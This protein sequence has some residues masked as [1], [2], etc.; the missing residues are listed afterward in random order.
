MQG[1]LMPNGNI[2]VTEERT[3]R[4]I[5]LRRPGKKNAITQNM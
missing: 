3:T 5:T 4:V 2:I 1:V